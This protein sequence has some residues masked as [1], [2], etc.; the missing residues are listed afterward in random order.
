MYG[1]VT[2]IRRFGA[3]DEA[4]LAGDADDAAAVEVEEGG[5]DG[6]GDKDEED[7]AEASAS[8]IFAVIVLA[9][10]F[11]RGHMFTAARQLVWVEALD[12]GDPRKKVSHRD[13]LMATN[14]GEGAPP[15][16]ILSNREF[17]V[18][19]MLAAGQSINETAESFSLSA[20]TI[21]THKMRLMQKLKLNNNAELIRYAIKHGIV[22]E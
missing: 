15:H 11:C 13:R 8:I 4:G 5:G 16:E 22:G 17:Q 12:D 1:T 2:R 14:P 9:V 20:K 18:L 7:D 6:D 3:L 19:Q 10:R 21:S